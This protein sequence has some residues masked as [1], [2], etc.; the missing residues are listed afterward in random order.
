MAERVV[1]ARILLRLPPVAV[2]ET[3]LV[4]AIANG[5]ERHRAIEAAAHARGEGQARLPSTSMSPSKYAS[6]RPMCPN[7]AVRMSERALRNTMRNSGSPSWLANC[8]RRGR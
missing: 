3:P 8:R 2:A 7:A 1:E 5:D 4:P 6:R